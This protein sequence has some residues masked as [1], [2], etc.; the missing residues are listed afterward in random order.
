MYKYKD[1]IKK[2]AIVDF[3][4]HH[5]NGT[6]E[7]VKFL[8]KTLLSI[9][10]ENKFGD[11]TI[12]QQIFKPWRDFDDAKNVLFVSTHVYDEEEPGRFYPSSGVDEENTE[13]DSDIYPGGIMNIP[14]FGEKKMSHGYRNSFRMKVI[15][16][17]IKFKPDMIFVSAGFDGHNNEHINNSYM[18]LTEFDYR[19][20]TE[21][22]MKI[23]N[24]FSEGRLISVLEGGYNINSGV[25]SSYA[26]SVLYHTKFLNICANKNKE[27]CVLMSK[28]KRKREYLKDLENFRSFKKR[29]EELYSDTINIR[30]NI[31]D[32][33]YSLR[34]KMKISDSKLENE[35]YDDLKTKHDESEIENPLKFS[36]L[37]MNYNL[38]YNNNEFIEMNK[39]NADTNINVEHSDVEIMKVIQN[40]KLYF[41]YFQDYEKTYNIFS[42]NNFSNQDDN[43]N[44]KENAFLKIKNEEFFNNF[45]NPNHINKYEEENY[46]INGNEQQKVEAFENKFNRVIDYEDDDKNKKTSIIDQ[47]GDNDIKYND[48]MLFEE[49]EVEMDEEEPTS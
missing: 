27:K 23:A 30:E 25:I 39:L 49:I 11:V 10:S 7:I 3:D 28:I 24:R 35:G 47:Q 48:N 17:L 37:E 38:N 43:L 22:L 44:D 33:R 14:I 45:E 41:K 16:R 26:Q 12:N 31:L 9:K 13:K 20:L 19:W 29:R 32:S 42:I 1:Q 21:E 36:N 15:P 18:K 5:G 8:S 46:F 6:Q 2:I 34:E 40:G 4:V